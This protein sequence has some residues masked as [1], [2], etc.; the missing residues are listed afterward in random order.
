M[1]PIRLKK[2]MKRDYYERFYHNNLLMATYLYCKKKK[3]KI[4]T[5]FDCY[6]SFK[7]GGT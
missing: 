2:I 6:T 1:S 7:I 5:S 3:K 4:F